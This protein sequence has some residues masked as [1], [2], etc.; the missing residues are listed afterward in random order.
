MGEIKIIYTPDVIRSLDDL[1]V[2]LYKKEYFGFVESAENYVLDI[3]DAVPER[4]KKT[5]HKK[6]SQFN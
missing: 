2:V 5:T 1:V 4:L 3:Y 6:N